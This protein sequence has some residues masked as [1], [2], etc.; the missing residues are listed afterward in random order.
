VR[1]EVAKGAVAALEAMDEAEK[2][3]F[4]HG[5]RA[6]RECSGMRAGG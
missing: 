2:Q 1:G 3:R 5:G 6:G 4:P